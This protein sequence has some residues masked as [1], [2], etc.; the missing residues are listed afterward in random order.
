MKPVSLGHESGV[1]HSFPCGQPIKMSGAQVSSN[2]G[3]IIVVLL[4]YRNYVKWCLVQL[5]YNLLMKNG[6]CK[7][8][9]LVIVL[10]SNMV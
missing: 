3:W 9:H 10:N 1:T 5:L 6:E 2:S 7:G 8:L 4:C